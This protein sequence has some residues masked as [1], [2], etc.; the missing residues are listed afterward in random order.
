MTSS[1]GPGGN[2]G[3]IGYQARQ[4]GEEAISVGTM[5]LQPH[6]VKDY[7]AVTPSHLPHQCTICDKKVYNLT[8]G[9][10]D[11][12]DKSIMTSCVELQS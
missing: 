8:V 5:V 1:V 7:H 4:G 6:Q 9:E 2:Q 3:F 11:R 12:K 10:L